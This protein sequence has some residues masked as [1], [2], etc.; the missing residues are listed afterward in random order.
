MMLDAL[1]DPSR[2]R[3]LELLRDGARAVGDIASEMPVTRPAVSQHLK[4][5]KGAGLV[6]ERRDG[7][8]HL[9]SVEPGGMAALRAYLETYWQT[10]LGRFKEIADE[11]GR[12]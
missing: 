2:R 12:Q 5:L 4:V 10:A 8:R 3:V 1:G 7:T 9:Y 11:G 6:T